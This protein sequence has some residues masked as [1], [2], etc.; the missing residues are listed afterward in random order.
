MT[1]DDG[2]GL[3]PSVLPLMH[4]H[5]C[6]AMIL[7]PGW[8][9]LLGRWHTNR[10]SRAHTA[11]GKKKK[12]IIRTHSAT[13]VSRLSELCE[14]CHG[15]LSTKWGFGWQGLWKNGEVGGEQTL[16]SVL[17]LSWAQ[18]WKR[19]VLY[20]ISRL[21]STITLIRTEMDGRHRYLDTDLCPPVAWWLLYC[22]NTSAD[23]R[24]SLRSNLEAKLLCISANTQE[25][26]LLCLKGRKRKGWPAPFSSSHFRKANNRGSRNSSCIVASPRFS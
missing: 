26:S 11:V 23:N 10:L 21:Q 4:R 5:P 1:M 6:P 20:A 9:W 22:L 18:T 24:W 25:S 14:H 16:G 17:T 13:I 7:F 12:K 3:I 8:S 19:R 2:K 15:L